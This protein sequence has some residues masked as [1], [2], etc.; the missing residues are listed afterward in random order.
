MNKLAK[1]SAVYLFFLLIF[2]WG[3]VVGKYEIFPYKIIKSISKEFIKIYKNENENF[4]ISISDRIKNDIGLFPSKHIVEIDSDI[5]NSNQINLKFDKR[6]SN[7]PVIKN[8]L[9]NNDLKNSL[10]GYLLIQ[11]FMDFES[12]LYGSILIDL[13][14]NVINK[15]SYNLFELSNKKE[16]LKNNFS[17]HPVVI[18]DDGSIVYTIN[19]ERWG[20]R[21]IKQSY[22]G[23][24]I[25]TKKG[26]FHHSISMNK[27]GNIWTSNAEESLILL[28]KNN[29]NVIKEIF[30]TDIFKK[31]R[32]LGLFNFHIQL[33]SDEN[34]VNDPYH[35]NDVEP[36]KFDTKNFNEGDLL[37]SFRNSN[38]VFVVDQNT[39]KIKWWSIGNTIRQHDP[40]WHD[41]FITIFDN[42]MRNNKIKSEK[43]YMS[44]VIKINLETNK[45]EILYDGVEHNAYSVIRGNHQLIKNSFLLATISSQGRI[46]ILDK[47]NDVKIE[48]INKYNKTFNGII[49]ESVWVDK[50][51]FNFNLKSVRCD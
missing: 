1:Y 31:N 3:L 20:E 46:L 47:F 32:N 17:T 27:N 16:S 6:R 48:F 29:G 8:F 5:S 38:L 19:D 41:G 49:M 7:K 37:L 18:F 40:D 13:D 11:G 15:W 9:N 10:N 23:K 33:P 44:R 25:W 21:I 14:G 34:I 28:D 50:D 39:Y 45:S 36:L 26:S 12:S 42:S 30:L 24:L 4:D 43:N 51:Y 35:L 2:S 22:C